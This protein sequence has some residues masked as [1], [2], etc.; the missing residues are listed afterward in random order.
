MPA[1]PRSYYNLLIQ[2]RRAA[3]QRA[4]RWYLVSRITLTFFVVLALLIS[5]GA[6]AVRFLAQ[7]AM[8]VSDGVITLPSLAHAT[9]GAH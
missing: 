9:E 2:M 8:P 1:I 5:S 6:I 7:R 3:P 4:K